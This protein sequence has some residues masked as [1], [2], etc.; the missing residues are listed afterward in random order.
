[1]K[2]IRF[3]T[4]S[5]LFGYVACLLACRDNALLDESIPVANQK[6]EYRDKPTV[7]ATIKDVSHPYDLYLN[8][9]HT[10]AYKYANIY[11]I[12]WQQYPNGKKTSIRAE[13]KLAED[14]GR[15]IGQGSGSLY[16]LQACFAKNYHFAD[17]GRYIFSLQQDM[18]ENPL[19]E[20]QDV[21]LRIVP[22]DNGPARK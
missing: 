7:M 22:S 9:R 6:W 5:V 18:R 15:W 21:G 13:V 16:S 14:D 12:I 1:M 8:L 2:P 17:T 3:L 4:R 20:I 11:V 10:A 19:P